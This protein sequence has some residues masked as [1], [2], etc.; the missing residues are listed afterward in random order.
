MSA[1]EKVVLPASGGFTGAHIC[2]GAGRRRGGAAMLRKVWYAEKE[3]GASRQFGDPGAGDSWT[4]YIE[5][6]QWRRRFWVLAVY[7]A[8]VTLLL[9]ARR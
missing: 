9:I 1:V 7:A 8:G 2:A 3:Q 4:P 5:M 6:R